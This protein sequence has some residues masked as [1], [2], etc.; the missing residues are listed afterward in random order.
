MYMYIYVYICIYVYIYMCVCVNVYMCVCKCT[1][2]DI[3]A[4][5]R[6]K[7]CYKLLSC[8]CPA[9]YVR[10]TSYT[11]NNYVS[12]SSTYTCICIHVYAYLC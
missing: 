5:Y 3:A 1:Y 8:M 9:H 11:I 4:V 12:I 7:N 10:A 6:G 2:I